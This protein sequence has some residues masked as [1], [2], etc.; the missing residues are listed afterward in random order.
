MKGGH[1]KKRSSLT[2]IPLQSHRS[3]GHISS[4]ST[5]SSLSRQPLPG[6]G[7][8]ALPTRSPSPPASSYFPEAHG[9]DSLTPTKDASS[10]FAYSTTLRR[11]HADSSFPLSHPS[12]SSSS[13][14]Q[15]I[16]DIVNKGSVGLWDRIVSIVSGE[17][18]ADHRAEE[19]LM[20]GNGHAGKVAQETP[21]SV[22]A[23]LTA[24]V[25]FFQSGDS[26]NTDTPLRLRLANFGPLLTQDFPQTQFRVYEN[27]T[28]TMSSR[29]KLL[30]PSF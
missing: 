18:S 26:C 27:Y 13:T 1:Q 8:A 15:S 2:E 24:D 22:H 25:C 28:V 10:H 6:R 7:Y 16:E 5:A 4:F 14:F 3:G 12:G 23:R 19:G 20:N 17:Q 30:N 11:H 21:S 29:S 9:S